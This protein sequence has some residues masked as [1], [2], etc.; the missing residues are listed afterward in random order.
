MGKHKSRATRAGEAASILTD[1]ADRLREAESY[2]EA[3]KALE[4]LDWSGVEDLKSEMESWRDNI[5]EKFSATQKFE[6]VSQ[7]ADDLD[8]VISDL[9][10]ID[11]ELP[12]PPATPEGAASEGKVEDAV[13]D[14]GDEPE[15]KSRAAEIADDLERAADSLTEVSFP[16]MY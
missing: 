4:G 6:E 9:N 8:S 14:D 1:A 13:E 7:A 5:E 12:A 2:D 3:A 11:T 15:W 16:G 10:G